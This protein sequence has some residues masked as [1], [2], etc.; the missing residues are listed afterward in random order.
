LF[1][2]RFCGPPVVNAFNGRLVLQPFQLFEEQTSPSFD[3]LSSLVQD[4]VIT[5]WHCGH[6]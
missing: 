3:G 4:R 5:C 1:G 6:L 2:W